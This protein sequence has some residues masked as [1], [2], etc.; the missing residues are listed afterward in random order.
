MKKR[1]K[2]KQKR[3]Q[4]K[5]PGHGGSEDHEAGRHLQQRLRQLEMELTSCKN[6][7]GDLSRQLKDQ[8]SD[9]TKR[10]KSGKTAS[11]ILLAQQSTR[12][13][14]SQRNAWKRHGYL[15]D[16]YEFHLDICQD[17][18]RARN[19]AD[20]DLRRQFGEEAGYTAQ[21]LEQILS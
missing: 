12:V 10:K 20:N 19:L 4:D 18:V 11:N 15:R 5:L 8:K 17:K 7:I 14:V 13:S 16:R 3:K 6:A 2:K 1:E 9:K 21:E